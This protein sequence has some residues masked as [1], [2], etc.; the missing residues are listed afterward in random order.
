[1]RRHRCA[2]CSRRRRPPARGRGSHD[3]GPPIS[4]ESA[5]PGTAVSVCPTLVPRFFLPSDGAGFPALG[6]ALF[7]PKGERLPVLSSVRRAGVGPAEAGAGS[8]KMTVRSTSDRWPSCT[9]APCRDV[10]QPRGRPPREHR[11]EK[12]PS[13]HARPAPRRGPTR[14]IERVR[15]PGA[16]PRRPH[17]R[18]RARRM[19]AAAP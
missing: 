16:R 17:A 9:R 18:L 5:R 8:E 11:H 1:M 3:R 19:P 2:R 7:G 14:S 13:L 6:Q 15:A 4:P 10:S 12:L